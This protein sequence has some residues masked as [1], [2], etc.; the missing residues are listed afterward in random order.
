MAAGRDPGGGWLLDSTDEMRGVL[1]WILLGLMPMT[2][3][4]KPPETSGKVL[5]VVSAARSLKLATGREMPV[6][7]WAVE[8]STPYRAITEAG[9]EVVVAT[10]GGRVPQPDPYSVSDQGLGGKQRA[11]KVRQWLN[12]LP[13]LK[14]PAVLEEITGIDSF[15]AVVIPGGYAPMVDLADSDAMGAILRAAMKEK[16]VVASICHG[17]AAFLSAKTDDGWA[18][19]GFEMVSFTNAEEKEWLKEERLPWQVEDALREAGVEWS[20][21]GNWGSH[22]VRDRNVLTAQNAPSVSAFT[23]QLLE[24]LAQRKKER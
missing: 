2:A 12:E 19:Q 14:K 4:A 16:K 15:D 1:L 20:S 18:F 23:K 21:T 24:M 9:Y 3:R 13:A 10:P 22:V 17:P 8:F 5:F 7:Y 11:E 6:G